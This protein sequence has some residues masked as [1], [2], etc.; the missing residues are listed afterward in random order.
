MTPTT[1]KIRPRIRA[2]RQTNIA[3]PLLQEVQ[4]GKESDPHDI[5]EVPVHTDCLDGDVVLR[6]ELPRQTTQ[7]HD[8]DAD[9]TA[10]D[11]GAVEAGHREEERAVH[12]TVDAEAFLRDERQ[13]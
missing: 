12:A 2:L 9:N 8:G 10:E 7:Q 11:V 6:A 4:R 3:Q 13:V 5:D 1:M